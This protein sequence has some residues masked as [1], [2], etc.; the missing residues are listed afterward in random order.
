ME[1]FRN[2]SLVTL[3]ATRWQEA[4]KYFMTNQPLLKEKR[5]IKLHKLNLTE[6]SK[7]ISVNRIFQR[8]YCETI[9]KKSKLYKNSFHG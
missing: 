3:S 2:A 4:K 1:N 8:T 9:L 5:I 7:A 6:M